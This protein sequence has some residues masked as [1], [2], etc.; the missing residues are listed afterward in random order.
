VRQA[1]AQVHGLDVGESR[2]EAGVDVDELAHVLVEL[3]HLGAR[4]DVRVQRRDG[5]LRSGRALAQRAQRFVPHAVLRRRP[6]VSHD[7]TWPWPKPGS[8]AARWPR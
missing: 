3:A 6:P 5:Q 8:R 2:Q 1:A 4:A 7:S